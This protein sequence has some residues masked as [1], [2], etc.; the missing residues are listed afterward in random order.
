MLS[1][2][3]GLLLVGLADVPTKDQEQQKLQGT[4]TVTAHTAGGKKT[5]PKEIATWR[6]IVKGN[7]ITARDGIDLLSAYVFRLD[8]S[9]S[10]RAIDLDVTAGP[11]K[12]RKVLGIYKLEGDTLTVCVPEPGKARPKEFASKEGSGHLLFVFQREK[13]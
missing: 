8:P 6:V 3:A 9:A 4:W 5:A 10:P 2:V 13:K 11:D 7:E 12:D 1:L